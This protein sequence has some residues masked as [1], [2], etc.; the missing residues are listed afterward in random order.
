MGA[1]DRGTSSHS[2]P[3]PPPAPAS[4]APT[5]IASTPAAADL[6]A[7]LRPSPLLQ[8]LLVLPPSPLATAA[9]VL[10][11]LS[12]KP[13]PFAA[14]VPL[15]SVE[16]VP[17]L[18]VCE[19]CGAGEVA[20]AA[21]GVTGAGAVP[22]VSDPEAHPV[23]AASAQACC[24][25]WLPVCWAAA[26]APPL[27]AWQACS[28]LRRFTGLRALSNHHACRRMFRRS[29]RRSPDRPACASHRAAAVRHLGHKRSDTGHSTLPPSWMYIISEG[30]N[31]RQAASWQ[32]C[33]QQLTAGQCQSLDR[34]RSRTAAGTL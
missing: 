2:S 12:L 6:L 24:C 21:R 31:W 26:A 16:H 22:D 23:A 27:P 25:F 34:R 5:A 28:T 10:T 17:L 8:A 1:V 7:L 30:G 19:S 20:V 4:A 11:P 15:P 13:L 14:H 33:Q 3:P 18:G 32:A 9:A 29:G